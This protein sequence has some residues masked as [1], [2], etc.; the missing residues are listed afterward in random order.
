[1]RPHRLPVVPMVAF[2]VLPPAPGAWARP[3]EPPREAQAPA[4]PTFGVGTAAVTLDVVVRDK[5]GNAV[6]DLKAS[7]FEVYEDGARQQVESFQVFGRPL[8]SAEA[9]VPRPAAAPAAVPP[10]PAV[11][12]AS[13]AA[14]A[15]ETRPQVIAFVF[16]RLSANARNTA[17]K[18][19]MTYL[20]R[21]HVEGDVVGVFAID[22]A[23]RTIQPFTT[24]PSL[25]R[26]GLERAASQAN[27]AFSGDR[28]RT[29]QIIDVVSAGEAASSGASGSAPSGPG[30]SS[31]ASGIAGAAAAGALNQAIGRIQVG[32]LRTFE[33]LERDQQGYASTNGLLSVVNGLKSLPGRKT[34][35]FFSEGL[36][37]PANVQ[38][39]FRSVI[40]NAN[41]AN[42]SVYAMDAGG[43][44]TQSMSEETRNEM[45][46]A[47]RRRLRQIESGSDSA[48]DGIMSRQLERNEDLLRL[49]PEA[50]LGTL[51]NETGGFLIRDTNDAAAA[52]RRM[53]EDMR[54]HYLLGYSPSNESYD[55]RFRSISVKVSRPGV[56]VQTRQGYLAIRAAESVPLR[57]F[58]APALAQF[59]RRPAPHAFPLDTVALSFPTAKKPGLVPVLVRVPGQ[60]VTYQLDKQDKSG[61]KLH[62]AELTVVARVKDQSGKEVDRLSQH[63][64]LSAPEASLEAA[65]RGDILFY[66]EADLGPGRYTVEA[67]AYDAV[68][69]KASVSTASLEVAATEPGRPRLS[70]IVLVGR[71][72]KASPS[73]QADNPLFYGETII[74]PNMGEP[75]RKAV[76]PNLGF[77]FAV[78]GVAP[79][80]PSPRVTIE[81]YRGDAPAGRVT[82]D[83]PA[84]DATGRIQYAGALPLQSFPAGSYRLKVTALTG[85]ASDSRQTSFTLAE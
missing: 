23:L 68:A 61:K 2:L 30:A 9:P 50:G 55:G 11:S 57:S 18:A 35:V 5:K 65:R 34:V 79:G 76:S 73:D 1:M 36:A 66:R 62:R 26:V 4:I 16:D 80:T 81:V 22:L 49:N 58:E 8:E 40:A 59:D 54:F 15:R 28:E 74:Y 31:Q 71:A 60:T 42:V 53:E 39:Q 24:E 44:R 51:A 70:S 82:A 38:A 7:D 12:T 75:F 45:L 29:R 21:G 19:A 25:I 69:D 46:Q 27:T 47:A 84:P 63:Y 56:Q 43:L 37:I 83:L 6:R 72:E 17:H 13:P 52:F 64:A 32:M 14:D 20:D 77:F 78:Y 10:A 48:N 41:R 33:A 67:V 3:Q 85:A